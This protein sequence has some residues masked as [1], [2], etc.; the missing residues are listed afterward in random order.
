MQSPTECTHT[1]HDQFNDPLPLKFNHYTDFKNGT[2]LDISH[3]MPSI[4]IAIVDCLK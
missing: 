1:Y 4:V 2:T 3:I